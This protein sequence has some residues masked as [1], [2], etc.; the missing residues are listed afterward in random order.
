MIKRTAGALLLACSA[1]AGAQDALNFNYFSASYVDSD[2][3]GQSGDGFGLSAQLQLTS[4]IHA[5]AEYSMRSFDGSN[6]GDVDLDFLSVGVGGSYPIPS[7]IKIVA[8]GAATW[9]QVDG[10]S[11]GGGA[12][13]TPPDDMGGGGGELCLPGDPTGFLCLPDILTAKQVGGSFSRRL[14]GYGVQVGIRALVWRTLEVGGRYRMREYDEADET[15]F[16]L[17]VNYGIT[18]NFSAGL[19]YDSFDELNLDEYYASVRY[20][21]GVGDSGSIW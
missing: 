3:S 17:G 8:F 14:D 7:P 6:D 5:T 19:S 4:L 13:V 2:A 1:T 20:T 12:P 9:E 11:S 16:S 10:S 15:I 21:F 18:E